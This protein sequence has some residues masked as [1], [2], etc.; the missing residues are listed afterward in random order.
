M[1]L[2]RKTPLKTN[3]PISKGSVNLNRGKALRAR[4]RTEE[5]KD[6]IMQEAW[7]MVELFDKHWAS[8][9]HK[10]EACEY[11]LWGENKTI[12]HHHLL[13]KSRY[14]EYKYDIENLMLLCADCHTKTEA[15]H[16]PEKVVEQ[17]KTIK[18]KYGL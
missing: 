9:E 18:E 8:K 7:K 3:K 14:K 5:E 6:I 16:P 17:T 15:G 1:A 2:Q 10:C 4:K 13:P 12:Y 11:T